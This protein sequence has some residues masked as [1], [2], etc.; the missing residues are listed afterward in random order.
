[1]DG[2]ITDEQAIKIYIIKSHYDALT[3]CKSNLE[4][5]IIDIAEEFKAQQELIQTVP[6][7]AKRFTA[8][9]IIS[10]LGV[11]MIQFPTAGHLCSWAR[12]TPANN[13]SANKKNP[14]GFLK[15]VNISNRY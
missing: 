5:A 8:I 11:N 2:K 1:M 14:L 9:K 6:G 4:K 13:E 10:E 12:L 15:Q 3:L 7:C